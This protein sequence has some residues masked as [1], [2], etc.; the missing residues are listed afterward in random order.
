MRAL[1]AGLCAG[2]LL[3]AACSAQADEP[4]IS[5]ASA[6]VNIGMQ[7]PGIHVR[8]V[9]HGAEAGKFIAAFNAQPPVSHEVADEVI[10]F[11][12]Q[13]DEGAVVLF[14]LK[15]CAFSYDWIVK[16]AWVEQNLPSPGA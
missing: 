7:H 15:G 8:D 13:P 11:E 14:A 6:V 2:F 4:C 10:V 12:R 9:L 5:P 16:H 3:L 1:V